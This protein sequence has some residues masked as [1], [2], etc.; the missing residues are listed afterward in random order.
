MLGIV[1]RGNCCGE[2]QVQPSSDVRQSVQLRL[3]CSPKPQQKFDCLQSTNY[4]PFIL[5]KLVPDRRVS[6]LPELLNLAGQPFLQFLSKN[7]K[8]FKL[9]TKS[10]LGQRAQP[11][12]RGQDETITAC[13]RAVLSFFGSDKGFSNIQLFRERLSEKMCRRQSR[14]VIWDMIYT[15]FLTLQL[16]KLLL[17]FSFSKRKRKSMVSRAILANFFEEP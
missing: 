11:G 7:G 6:H 15:L 10:W 9:D 16:S 12:E 4:D 8:P 1:G 14:K 3:V 17:L 2:V 5:R 13:V